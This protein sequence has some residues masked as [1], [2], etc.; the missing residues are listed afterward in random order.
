M[1]DC[2]GIE[3]EHARQPA[4]RTGRR[5]RRRATAPARALGGARCA[6]LR[7]QI[8]KVAIS[9]REEILSTQ[10][11]LDSLLQELRDPEAARLHSLVHGFR[12]V[13]LHSRHAPAYT[14]FKTNPTTAVAR[15]RR[16]PIAPTAVSSPTS[17]IKPQVDTTGTRLGTGIAGPPGSTMTLTV[18]D[19]SPS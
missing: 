15:P 11:R 6:D 16:K 10:L 14:P 3:D 13:S 1:T 12:E 9:F 17:P 7:D 19:P 5:A 2:A 8:G 18:P 4:L